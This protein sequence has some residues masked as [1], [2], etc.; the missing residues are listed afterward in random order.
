MGTKK[1][2]TIL[3]ES[4]PRDLSLYT[5]DEILDSLETGQF[6]TLHTQSRPDF[7]AN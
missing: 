4:S 2:A 7:K 6:F 3:A 5:W 1:M